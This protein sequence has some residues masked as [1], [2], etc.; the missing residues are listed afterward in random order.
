[1]NILRISIAR[2]NMITSIEFDFEKDSK[3]NIDLELPFNRLIEEAL[4]DLL[5][6]YD[7]KSK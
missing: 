4:R 7:N 5:N 2:K 6:K 1:M 3:L